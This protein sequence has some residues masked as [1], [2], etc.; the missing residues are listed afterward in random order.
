M[1]SQTYL[2][3]TLLDGV[4]HFGVGAGFIVVTED[5][6]RMNTEPVQLTIQP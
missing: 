3:P 2:C 4:R 1:D 6:L 5:I